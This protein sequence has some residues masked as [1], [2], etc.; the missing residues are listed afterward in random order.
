[1][2]CRG[3][4]LYCGR[5][6]SFLIL[7]PGFLQPQALLCSLLILTSLLYWIYVLSQYKM[8]FCIE[9]LSDR[10]ACTTTMLLHFSILLIA[11]VYYLVLMVG[12]YLTRERNMHSIYG[13][14][15][16]ASLCSPSTWRGVV[17][18]HC[19]QQWTCTLKCKSFM[20][21]LNTSDT[22]L[23]GPQYNG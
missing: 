21:R 22:H 17:G 4:T 2:C 19:S 10:C 20:I 3:Q 18:A 11:P 5:S 1:M 14:I 15:H 16:S 7:L 23:L 9:Y 6:I 8:L 13:N 12:H